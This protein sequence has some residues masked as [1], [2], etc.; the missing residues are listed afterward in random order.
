[1]NNVSKVY[2]EEL[3]KILRKRLK[4][5][6]GPT[7]NVLYFPNDIDFRICPKNGI[8]TIKWA[9]LYI[10]GVETSNNNP[11][12]MLIATKN[13]RVDQVKEFGY[14]P[15]LPFRQNSFRVAVA[16]DPIKRFMS[17]C[18]YIKQEYVKNAQLLTR[19]EDL[20]PENLKVLES[21]SDV[22]Q[23]PDNI[24]DIIDGVWK[25]DIQNSHFFT[26]TYYH[27]AIGQ[28]DKIF[29]MSN[30]GVMLEWLRVKT[31]ATKKIDR[32]HSNRT[33]GQWFGGVD[34]LTTDQKKRIIRI[35]EEDYDYGWTEN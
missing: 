26:Q 10:K 17:A 16:R 4:G 22:D 25:G 30:F 24:D 31:N 11:E 27:G 9:L 35:Y 12:S 23:L 34:S 18:E 7:E 29:K 32:I 19:D 3:R 15:E 5:T 2:Q 8:S 14:K 13:W 1:M 33:S 20:T 21:L 6:M 28:Y